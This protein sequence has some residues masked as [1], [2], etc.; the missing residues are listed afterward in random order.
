VSADLLWPS[1]GSPAG[2]SSIEAVPLAERRFP[3]TTYDVLSRA[4][5]LWP[6]QPGRSVSYAGLVT[7]AIG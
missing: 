5:S 1:Y 4:V 2:L 3:G 7:G 6:G